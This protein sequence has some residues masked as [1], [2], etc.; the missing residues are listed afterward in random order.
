MGVP[1][2]GS[3]KQLYTYGYFE[4]YSAS[5]E[6]AWPGRGVDHWVMRNHTSNRWFR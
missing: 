3:D 5:S 1:K 6:E 4:K 2:M